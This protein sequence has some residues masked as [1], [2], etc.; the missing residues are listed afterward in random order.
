MLDFQ[1]ILSNAGT[2]LVVQSA[3]AGSK[4]L[5]RLAN[6]TA[7]VAGHVWQST[8]DTMLVR[9]CCIRV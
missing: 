2:G 8:V 1:K 5:L 4:N 3:A 6:G 9:H 7:Y